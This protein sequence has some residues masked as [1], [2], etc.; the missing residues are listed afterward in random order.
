MQ[1][2]TTARREE[3]TLGLQTPVA[4]CDSSRPPRG[5]RAY[6]Q[7]RFLCSG[8]A[9]MR[10]GRACMRSG[11]AASKAFL[12]AG[13][14]VMDAT[15]PP[16]SRPPR[17]SS[18][19]C[20]PGPQVRMHAAASGRQLEV[21]IALQGIRWTIV[22]TSHFASQGLP[23]CRSPP[24]ETLGVTK[25]VCGLSFACASAGPQHPWRSCGSGDGL[26]TGGGSG[27]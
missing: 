4:P 16:A 13:A 25:R 7:H 22:A 2:G 8:R 14:A 12:L 18:S 5:Q 3:A 23:T 27:G 11:R 19:C 6:K 10:A 26:L 24:P 21:V 9:C 20:S 1:Q 15:C 17:S